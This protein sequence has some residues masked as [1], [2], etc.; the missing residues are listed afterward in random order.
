MHLVVGSTTN[1]KVTVVEP[2]EVVA[3]TKGEEVLSL[4]A[5]TL[6]PKGNVMQMNGRAAAAGSGTKA[7]IATEALA[8]LFGHFGC[9]FLP[10]V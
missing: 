9:G 8:P 3:H 2:A 7:S 4:I 6:G 10:G 1:T 5:A